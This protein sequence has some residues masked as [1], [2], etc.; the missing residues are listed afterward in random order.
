[1]RI[2]E[3]PLELPFRNRRRT[4]CN[5]SSLLVCLLLLL[6]LLLLRIAASLEEIADCILEFLPRIPVESVA[7]LAVPVHL[8]PAVAAPFA[9]SHVDE[10]ISFL[11]VVVNV[12]IVALLS[13]SAWWEGVDL[14]L[15]DERNVR[16]YPRLVLVH[17][18]QSILLFV[19]PLHVLLLV[20]D[21]V[22]PDVHQPVGPDASP[23]KERAQVETAAV[24]RNN[25]VDRVHLSVTY[26]RSCHWIEV[27]VCERMGDV[28]RVVDV[29]VAV[30]D[31]FELLE[32][33]ALKRVVRLHDECVRVQPPE[34]V[35]INK[36]DFLHR[37]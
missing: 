6:F 5:A 25:H 14:A 28:E 24:L 36:I 34:P 22:P 1:M 33:V 32:D 9:S 17:V 26:G 19:L 12:R 7:K 13:A 27:F 35:K 37:L 21:R 4:K 20:A 8:A 18:L 30:G 11:F 29:D 15:L 3:F 2:A 16:P 23:H 31:G 10:E